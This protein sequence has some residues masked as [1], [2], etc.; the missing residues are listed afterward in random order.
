MHMLGLVH[1]HTHTQYAHTACTSAYTYTNTHTHRKLKK[2]ASVSTERSR[3]LVR[4]W[5]TSSASLST[6]LFLQTF[7]RGYLS[8][9]PLINLTELL[10]ERLSCPPTLPRPLSRLMVLCLSLIQDSPNRRWMDVLSVKQIFLGGGQKL[11][12]RKIWT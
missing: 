4:R 6:P 12:V 7:N 5:E 1:T 3:T 9:P 11:N 10:E 2:H 8:Q